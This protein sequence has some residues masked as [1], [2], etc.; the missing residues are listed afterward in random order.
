MS[1]SK[2]LF[3]D[4]PPWKRMESKALRGRGMVVLMDWEEKEERKAGGLSI[5]KGAWRGGGKSAKIFLF[6]KPPLAAV[7]SQPWYDVS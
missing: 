2:A 7:F 5:K 4:K 6:S 1:K 3:L